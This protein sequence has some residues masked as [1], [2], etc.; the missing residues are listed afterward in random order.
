[1]HL[2][3]GRGWV[4]A[5][6][7][8]PSPKLGQTVR[9]SLISPGL[10][11]HFVRHRGPGLRVICSTLAGSGEWGWAQTQG[12]RPPP[13]RAAGPTQEAGRGG[14]HGPWG[15]CFPGKEAG[16]TH[17]PSSHLPAAL[18]ARSSFAQAK[19][20]G[21]LYHITEQAEHRPGVG[22]RER[23]PVSEGRAPAEANQEDTRKAGTKLDAN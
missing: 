22:C 5:F 2:E 13:A 3:E 8:N 1:M 12:R 9:P 17:T 4:Q 7:H 10:R 21:R 23:R 19:E 16:C 15:C 20:P 11:I 18:G 14:P 6:N